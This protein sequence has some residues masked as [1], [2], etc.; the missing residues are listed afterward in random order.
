VFQTE[1][2]AGFVRHEVE[3]QDEPMSPG[4][5]RPFFAA[6]KRIQD[7]FPEGR[8]PIRTALV[9]SRN[10]PAHKRVVSTF[11]SWGIHTDEAFFLGGIDKAGA[12]EVFRPNIFFDDQMSHLSSA[13]LHVPAAHVIP[14]YE[15]EPLF[16]AAELPVDAVPSSVDMGLPA[17]RKRRAAR[18]VD[19]DEAP[20]SQPTTTV[21]HLSP[22]QG[23]EARNPMDKQL[24]DPE[25]VTESKPAV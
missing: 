22:H 20:A 1:K 21:E 2:L 13:G 6:L 9:T 3:Y 15:Q 4:P 5:F 19:A 25:R 18:L 17:A 8:S 14:H 12:L 16:I 11:R 10:A 7:E 23:A 24:H